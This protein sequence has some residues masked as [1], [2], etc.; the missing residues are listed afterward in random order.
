MQPLRN[1]GEKVILKLLRIHTTS[2][3]NRHTS[4]RP[5]A[6]DTKRGSSAGTSVRGVGVYVGIL[7]RD[8]NSEK[9]NSKAEDAGMIVH[10]GIGSFQL[11]N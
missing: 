6:I 4:V 10:V 2:V 3:A 7:R 1:L 8:G 9:S 5:C 11:D